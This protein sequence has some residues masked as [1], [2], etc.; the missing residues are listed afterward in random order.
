MQEAYR[1]FIGDSEAKSFDLDHRQKIGYNMSQY[2]RMVQ[3]GKQQFR[4]LELAKLRAASLKYKVINNLDKY[5]IEFSANFESRGGKVIWAV[6]RDDAVKEILHIMKK[7]DASLVVKS[8]SMVTEEIDLNHALEKTRIEVLETDLGEY[9]VQLA[10]ERP[11]HIVTPAMHKSKADVAS[12]F[13]SRF[14]LSR[15]STPEQIT[16]YVRQKLRKKFVKADVGITGCNFLIADTGAVCVTE[17]EGNGLMSMSFPRV[18]IVVTGIEKIIPSLVDLDLF[19]PLL[20]T[21]GTG[22]QMTVY[23][24]I[25]TGP[26]QDG[27]VDGPREMYVVLVD[28]RRTE[29]LK[30]KE[31]KSALT[32]IRCGACLNACP[33]YRNI[34]GHS[35]QVTYSGPIGAVIS[36]FLNDLDEYKHLSYASSLCGKCSEVCPVKIPLHELILFNRNEFVKRSLPPSSERLAMNFMKRVLLSRKKMDFFG[37]AAKNFFM[38]KFIRKSWGDRRELPEFAGKSFRQIWEEKRG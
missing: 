21:H 9:I 19:W 14:G 31:Q 24:S 3:E 13:H 8:K 10:G 5:L 25:L 7:Y 17:N 37:S 33:V 38:R 34:G 36:P 22:Q 23:N 26:A 16:N 6:N 4:N 2:E 20:A 18:H 1:K 29:V 15:E 11:Y 12:L 27:E 30:Q 35:Y 28:N 32:C